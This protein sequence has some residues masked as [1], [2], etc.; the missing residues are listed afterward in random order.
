M[1]FSWV[2]SLSFRKRKQGERQ[3]DVVTVYLR[4]LRA[5]TNTAWESYW[6]KPFPSR[7]VCPRTQADNAYARQSSSI[8]L[9]LRPG[10]LESSITAMSSNVTSQIVSHIP[11]LLGRPTLSSKPRSS[12]NQ[13]RTGCSLALATAAFSANL[14]VRFPA[15]R[16]VHDVDVHGKLF[17][18]GDN[19]QKEMYYPAPVSSTLGCVTHRAETPA[20]IHPQSAN[21]RSQHEGS[22]IATD[23]FRIQRDVAKNRNRNVLSVRQLR[24]SVVP[25]QGV[26]LLEKLNS[27]IFSTIPAQHDMKVRHLQ[28]RADLP[29]VQREKAKD[30][31]GTHAG[32]EDG[33]RDEL[34][35]SRAD[36]LEELEK[37]SSLNPSEE[38]SSKRLITS[39]WPSIWF[40]LIPT[41]IDS[42]LGNACRPG[43]VQHLYCWGTPQRRTVAPWRKGRDFQALFLHRSH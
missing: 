9:L 40:S 28:P 2:L 30:G 17:E 10:R 42:A 11:V 35:Q 1:S 39:V 41:V 29:V 27:T 15:V 5:E 21:A 37:L 3:G 18:L 19:R 4:N 13:A 8:V 34:V 20:F 31:V 25:V 33:P 26:E 38:S 14:G 36:S 12:A 7:R 6:P 16:A 32:E 22:L 23:E 24:C 43:E